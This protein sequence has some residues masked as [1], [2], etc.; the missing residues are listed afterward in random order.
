MNRYT[1]EEVSVGQKVS[2]LY[3]IDEEKMFLF[4]E[5]TGDI[6]PLHNSPEYAHEKGYEEK[7]VYGMLT[8]AALSTLAGVY[9]PGERSLIHSVNIKYLKPVY[10]SNCPLTVEGEVK[11]K[12]DRFRFI[13]LN[14]KFTDKKGDK[15][16]KGDMQVGFLED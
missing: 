7:V 14:F 3:E 16:A 12:D 13:K 6:N 9:M 8:G 11:E 4:K 10:I 5:I 15:V 1:F 2:F